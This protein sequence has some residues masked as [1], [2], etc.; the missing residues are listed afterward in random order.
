MLQRGHLHLNFHALSWP[1]NSR[2]SCIP[3]PLT[4]TIVQ[5]RHE[6]FALLARTSICAFYLS[7]KVDHTLVSAQDALWCIFLVG[8]FLT[9]SPRLGY[10]IF[11][12][13]WG[14]LGTRNATKPLTLLWC[15]LCVCTQGN[16]EQHLPVSPIHCQT[17]LR[18]LFYYLRTECNDVVLNYTR[19]WVTGKTSH[20]L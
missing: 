7:C 19:S 1:Y 20:I 8:S 3:D 13:S 18:E 4:I 6:W 9:A 11:H 16:L 17:K 5:E 14:T 2:A 15:K 10:F 12:F